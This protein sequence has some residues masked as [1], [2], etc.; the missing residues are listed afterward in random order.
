M[1]GAID[2]GVDGEV[3]GGEYFGG[4]DGNLVD[5]RKGAVIDGGLDGDIH[6][7]DHGGSICKAWSCTRS[8]KCIICN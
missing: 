4:T 3:H 7:G 1:D 6:V 5:Y 8:L 2:G